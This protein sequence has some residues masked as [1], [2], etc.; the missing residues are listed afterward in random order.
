MKIA[1]EDSNRFFRRREREVEDSQ[2]K[3]RSFWDEKFW[4]PPYSTELC[5]K[6]P[7]MRRVFHTWMCKALT[8]ERLT[9]M[10]HQWSTSGRLA[11]KSGNREVGQN[12]HCDHFFFLLRQETRSPA[13]RTHLTLL[14]VATYDFWL[15]S[16]FILPLRFPSLEKPISQ[17][18]HNHLWLSSLCTD[19][20]DELAFNFAIY[21]DL[22]QL[23]VLEIR[24]TFFLT[25]AMLCR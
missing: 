10:P 23:T 20:P 8:S 6:T 5:V 4:I 21:H 9:C 14:R 2:S 18:V 13:S 15:N 3:E 1:I 7:Y 24:S 12:L 16:L 17:P 25:S 19:H 22:Q 11:K